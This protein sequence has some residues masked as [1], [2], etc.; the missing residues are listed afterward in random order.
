MKRAFVTSSVVL[1][2]LLILTTGCGSSRGDLSSAETQRRFG[3]PQ[4]R[5][6]FVDDSGANIEAARRLGWQT[7]LFV[8]ASMLERDLV[9]RALL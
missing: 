2:A 1:A 3:V 6:L 9:D 5:M 7:H 4:G 8:D